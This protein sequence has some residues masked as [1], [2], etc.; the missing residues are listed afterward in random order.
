[1]RKDPLLVLFVCYNQPTNR[2]KKIG[3]ASQFFFSCIQFNV[4]NFTQTAFLV[5]YVENKSNEVSSASILHTVTFLIQHQCD[6]LNHFCNCQGWRNPKQLCAKCGS[7][8]PSGL[9]WG[10]ATPRCLLEWQP[11]FCESAFT[12]CGC[13]KEGQLWTYPVPGHYHGTE[14]HSVSLVSLE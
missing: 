6:Q 4:I 2:S 10:D 13:E 12:T 8:E 7:Y 5:K 9:Q 14:G 1:M 11:G 3:Q